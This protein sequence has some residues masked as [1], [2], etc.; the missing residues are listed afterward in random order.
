M[1]YRR[2]KASNKSTVEADNNKKIAMMKAKVNENDINIK[3]FRSGEKVKELDK[4]VESSSN[5]FEREID[6]LETKVRSDGYKAPDKSS[7][8]GKLVLTV[9]KR[10]K[11]L[12]KSLKIILLS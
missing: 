5:K 9:V 1:H 7:E 8:A 4:D 12:V 11:G 10:V 2:E 3:N 6:K